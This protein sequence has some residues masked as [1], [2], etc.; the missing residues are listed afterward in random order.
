MTQTSFNEPPCKKTKTVQHRYLPKHFCRTLFLI[1]ISTIAYAQEPGSGKTLDFDGS[2]DYINLG[3]DDVFN[4][5]SNLTIQAWVKPSSTANFFMIFTHNEGFSNSDWTGY[6]FMVNSGTKTIRFESCNTDASSCF[7]MSGTTA[8]DDGGWHHVAFTFDG[9][10]A[11]LYVDGLQENQSSGTIYAS[12]SGR[13]TYIGRRATSSGEYFEGQIDELSVW[14]AALSQSSLRDWI[15][16]KITSSHPNYSDLIAYYNFDEGTG[17]SL[18]D[19]RSSYDGTLTNM[20]ASDWIDSGAAIGDESDAEYGNGSSTNLTISHVDGSSFT[21]SNFNND[22]S[23][24]QMYLVN[25]APNVTTAPSGFSSLETSRYVGLF[26]VGGTDGARLT[27]NYTGNS[28]IDGSQSETDARMLSRDDNTGTSWTQVSYQLNTDISTNSIIAPGQVTGEYIA[29]FRNTTALATP[30]GSG[31]MLDFDGSEDYVEIPDEDRFDFGTDDFTVEFWFKSDNKPTSGS[32]FLLAKLESGQLNGWSVIA[33]D[34]SGSHHLMFQLKNGTTGL[35]A[36]T[37][38]DWIDGRWHHVAAFRNGNNQYIYVDGIG[39]SNNPVTGADNYDV[40]N[41]RDFGIGARLSSAGDNSH[42]KGNVDEVRIWN[43]ALSETEIRNWMTR[44]VTSEHPQFDHLVGY[45]R[46]DEN[47]GSSTTNWVDET[48]KNLVNMNSADWVASGAALGDENDL[49]YGN[50][51]STNLTLSHTDGSSFNFSGFN[52]DILGAHIYMVN[53]APNVTTV[54]SGFSL[55]ETSRYVGLFTVGGTDGARL[56]YNYSGNSQIDGSPNEADFRLLSRAD[57]SIAEWTQTSYQ[58]NTDT[59]ANSIISPKQKTGVYVGGFSNTAA[60][61]TPPGSGYALDFDGMDEY[62]EIPDEDRFDFGTDDFTVEFWFK[63]DNKPSSGSDFILAKFESGQQNGWDVLVRDAS[64]SHHIMFQLKN[65]TTGLNAETDADW[66]DGQWHHVA[67][68]RNGNNQYIY[69]DGVG[70]SNNPV[71][72]ADN[73]DVSNDRDLG[74]GA[75]LSS[76]GVNSHFKGSVD[77]V[78]IWNTALTESEIRS[79]MTRKV[80]HEHPQF[81]HLVGYFRLDENTGTSTTNWADESTKNLVNMDAADWVDSGAALGDDSDSDYGNGSSTSLTLSH[82]DGS[83]FSF[84][85]FNSDISGAHLYLVNEAPNYTTVPSGFSS[86]ETSR[87]IGLFTVGGTDGASMMYNYLGNTAITGA[88][89][90]STARLLS[91]DD[92]VDQSW[93]KESYQLQTNTSSTSIRVHGQQTGEFLAGF[94]NAT[95]LST[96]PGSGT[97]LEFDGMDEYVN[98]PDNVTVFRPDTAITISA[99]I[100]PASVS[101]DGII[102]FKE[103]GPFWSSWYFALED[104]QIA[105]AVMNEAIAEWPK[106]VSNLSTPIAV[107][108]WYHVAFVFE[109]NNI[110]ATDGQI[111]INGE[112][113]SQTFNFELYTS[114][115]Q[116]GYDVEPVEIARRTSGSTPLDHFE[117]LIDEVRI[118]NAALTHEEIRNWMTRKVTN[119][120]PKFSNLIAYFRM[121]EGTGSSTVTNWV[122]ESTA[123]IPNSE[124]GSDW[125][126]SGAPLGDDV[127]ILFEAA[128]IATSQSIDISPANRGTMTATVA[129]GSPTSIIIYYINESPNVTTIPSG[130]TSFDDGYFGVKVFGGT[131]PT[132]DI[133]FDYTNN[134]SVKDKNDPRLGTRADNSAASWTDLGATLN[135]ANNTLTFTGLSGT[136]FIPG[137]GDSGAP[138]PVTWLD[139]TATIGEKKVE[140]VWK[141]AQELNNDYF[142][143]ERSTDGTNYNVIGQKAG[144]GTNNEISTYVFTDYQPQ[145]GSNYYRIKQVDFDGQFERSQAHHI[146]FESFGAIALSPN[147][148]KDKLVISG[149]SRLGSSIIVQVVNLTG[150]IVQNEFVDYET[151]RAEIQLAPEIRP[152][153]YLI[154]VRSGN[155]EIKRKIVISR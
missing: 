136:E 144:K 45:F 23:G 14:T 121:D 36:E 60:L 28:Q 56:T 78:R 93:A 68:F 89:D 48:T 126:S 97:A 114:S 125:M 86:L 54:P 9:T 37:D 128:G 47:T 115:F 18:G 4:I 130:L 129:G 150:Q 104:D 59:S 67:A 29:G 105:G 119:D 75:R 30:P 145:P 122:D 39:S 124:T 88:T 132:Y 103:H 134:P 96:P 17:T 22:I 118:W 63:S 65:G 44:K 55:L 19:S 64:G 133:S 113:V 100:K 57:N 24:A 107:D 72:G 27:Y 69:V 85:D 135:T 84:S 154:R 41:D 77:E 71:S 33:R 123:S 131:S 106:W 49:E 11:T 16:K 90:P 66:T 32:D 83:S 6:S 110:D 87:Y 99:W 146:W 141:T 153:L 31:Y 25:E 13:P 151:K 155:T 21:F 38:A 35:N 51:S 58:L 95:S 61:S 43:V 26:T 15:C 79:W 140:L 149:D 73:Y 52:T 81:D 148:T 50:G 112:A 5:S 46:L 12:P 3:I 116:I 34:A 62:V 101:D 20:D 138:L 2:N 76:G 70:S 139:F 117:G 152:G 7:V 92:N 94:S 142:D 111:Y 120:H 91:R 102:V 1:L 10:T 127:C 42:F 82:A 108:S 40:S 98:V 8:L 137:G 143:I 109:K 74:I 147:P 53:E 80:T